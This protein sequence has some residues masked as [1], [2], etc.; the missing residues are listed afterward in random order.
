[1]IAA[2]KLSEGTN[3]DGYGIK[4]LL[5]TCKLIGIADNVLMAVLEAICAI[6][7]HQPKE[8]I[9]IPEGEEGEQNDEQ[10]DRMAEQNEEIEKQNELFTKLK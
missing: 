6:H 8:L 5:E 7:Y 2:R 3:I 1:M 9:E 4:F 10:R